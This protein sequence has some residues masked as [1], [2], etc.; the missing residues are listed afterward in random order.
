VSVPYTYLDPVTGRHKTGHALGRKV[1]T[2]WS[3]LQAYLLTYA[4]KAY[5]DSGGFDEAW[6]GK[7]EVIKFP[8]DYTRTVDNYATARG[9][10]TVIIEKR[11]DDVKKMFREKEKKAKKAAYDRGVKQGMKLANKKGRKQHG[12]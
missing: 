2:S 10:Q 11:R 9:K 8:Y 3:A 1:F 5:D 6:L 7:I 12:M 4:S